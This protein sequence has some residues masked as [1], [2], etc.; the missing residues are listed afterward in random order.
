[1]AV[2]VTGEREQHICKGC[3]KKIDKKAK[4]RDD[5]PSIT[6]CSMGCLEKSGD[7]LDFCGPHLVAISKITQSEWLGVA[8]ILKLAVSYVFAVYTVQSAAGLARLLSVLQLE[9]HEEISSPELRDASRW[10]L[11]HMHA[12]HP[13]EVFTALAIKG[14]DFTEACTGIVGKKNTTDAAEETA[15]HSLMYRLLRII[16]YNAQPLSLHGLQR[17]ELLSLLPTVARINHSCRPNAVLIYD[18]STSY[19]HPAVSAS[20]VPVR[21]IS[22]DEEVTL[23][24]LQSLC[25]PLQTRRDLLMQGFA[26]HCQCDRCIEDEK[27]GVLPEPAQGKIVQLERQLQ[28]AVHTGQ[29]LPAVLSEEELE[30]TMDTVEELLRGALL[31]SRVIAAAHDSAAL[32]QQQV[33]RHAKTPVAATAASASVQCRREMLLVRAHLAVAKCWEAAGCES[34]LCQVEAVV[35]SAQIWGRL[36]GTLSAEPLAGSEVARIREDV[37][38]NLASALLVLNDVYLASGSKGSGQN[39]SDPALTSTVGYLTM[40]RDVATRLHASI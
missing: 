30:R 2:C 21:H 28:H 26:F 7:Y 9:S 23:S 24:Y 5:Y 36:K 40:L 39:A 16:K 4:A 29:V 11:Q 10:L 19:E 1:V 37:R 3:L 33:Q 32:V 20:I 6:F 34:L 38:R 18:A 27:E 22:E 15:A 8:H 17:V 31:S 12:A 14:L 25:A 35:A 13:S